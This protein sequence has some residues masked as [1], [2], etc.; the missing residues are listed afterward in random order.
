MVIVK[1]VLAGLPTLESVSKPFS[2]ITELAWIILS[3]KRD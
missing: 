1:L 3:V 2:V